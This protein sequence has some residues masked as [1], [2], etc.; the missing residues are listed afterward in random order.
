MRA[1]FYLAQGARQTNSDLSYQGRFTVKH[2]QIHTDNCNLLIP[3][4][5]IRRTQ[6]DENQQQEWLPALC[7]S[8]SDSVILFLG[9]VRGWGMNFFSTSTLVAILLNFSLR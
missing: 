1:V 8:T 5:I 7:R 3:R 9:V 6:A 4:T 2:N